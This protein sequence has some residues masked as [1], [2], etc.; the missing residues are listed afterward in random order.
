MECVML[1][2]QNVKQF[3]MHVRKRET[4]V[5]ESTDVFL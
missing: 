2:F 4:T 5:G 1:L 3:S